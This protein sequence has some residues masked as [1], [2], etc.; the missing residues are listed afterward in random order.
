MLEEGVS[1]VIAMRPVLAALSLK[2]YVKSVPSECSHSLPTSMCLLYMLQDIDL[3]VLE[4]A[5]NDEAQTS[6]GLDAGM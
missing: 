5:V 6:E 3:I 1:L 4:F 2:Q